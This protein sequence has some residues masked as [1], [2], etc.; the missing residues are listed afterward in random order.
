MSVLMID[1]GGSNVKLMSSH[2]GEVRKLQSGKKLSAGQM[3]KGVLELV[4]DWEFEKISIGFPGLVRDGQPAREPLNLGGGWMDFDYGAAFGK[5]VRFI[6]DASM[7]ALGNYRSG[8]LLF[9]G[10]GTSTGTTIIVDDAVIPIEIGMLKLTRKGRFMDLLSKEALKADGLEAW[11]K[12]A[13]EAVSL[14]RNVFNPDVTV[15]GGGN[16]KKLNPPPENCTLV[17]NRSAYV[18]ARRLWEDADLYASPCST[19][20]RIHH[21]EAHK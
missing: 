1:V 11:A 16:A 6:N 5:P 18:G 17:D 15:L 12:S 20:W 3:V 19:S 4:K 2:D 13:H 10:L 8:R 7:Q 21:N 9:L 14:L